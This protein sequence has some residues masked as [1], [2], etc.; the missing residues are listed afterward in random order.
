MRCSWVRTAKKKTYPLALRQV[1]ADGV[2]DVVNHMRTSC[3]VGE[4]PE[5]VKEKEEQLRGSLRAFY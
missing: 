4:W 5:D 2:M 3:S 1:L